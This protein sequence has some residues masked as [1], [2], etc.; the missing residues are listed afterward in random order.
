MTTDLPTAAPTT[1]PATTVNAFALLDHWTR[2]RSVALA[3]A[4]PGRYLSAEDGEEVGLVPLDQPII[5]I[6]RGLAADVRIEDP[7]VS[8]RHAIIAQ[9]GDGA[10]VLD[11]RSSNGTHVNGRPVTI[12]YL[13]DGDVLRI[14]RVVLRFVE[15]GS[16]SA[17][18]RC[19]ASRW[20]RSL[21]ARRSR[22]RPDVSRLTTNPEAADPDAPR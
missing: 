16:P 15:I 10:R 18:A 4:P 17:R 5:R 22:A 6:G 20:P 21:A 8:R 3:D 12:G 9:R 11:D 13:D 1:E 2:S 19:A 14:G 7:Q